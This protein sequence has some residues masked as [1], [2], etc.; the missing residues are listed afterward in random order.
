MFKTPLNSTF[1]VYKN[2]KKNKIKLTKFKGRG[3]IILRRRR[4]KEERNV[5][6]DR[7]NKYIDRLINIEIEHIK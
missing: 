5:H 7:I 4:L 2:N 3:N 1:F 6:L